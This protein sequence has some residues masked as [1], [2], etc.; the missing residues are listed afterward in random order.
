[1]STLS[2]AGV[3]LTQSI[4]ITAEAVANRF[5]RAGLLG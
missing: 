1:M 2:A 4:E 5:V 3:S